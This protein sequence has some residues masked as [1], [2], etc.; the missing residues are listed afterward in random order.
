MNKSEP[1]F[2]DDRVIV[3]DDVQKMSEKELKQEI[4]KLEKEAVKKKA[5]EQKLA[6]II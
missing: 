5:K 2:L 1:Y 3:P 6:A 4:A